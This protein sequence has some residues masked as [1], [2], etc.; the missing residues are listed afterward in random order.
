MNYTTTKKNERRLNSFFVMVILII[1]GFVLRSQDA[2]LM[3]IKSI[4]GTQA[5]VAHDFGF[6]D[7]GNIYMVGAF[8]GTMDFDPGPGTYTLNSPGTS[9]IFV[10]KMDP[11]GNFIWAK[12]MGG[13]GTFNTP[14]SMLVDSAG[15]SYIAGN[16]TGT[17]DFDP[18]VG[19]Y[20]VT[21][22]GYDIFLVKLNQNGSLVWAKT[23]GGSNSENANSL[24]FDQA[25]NIVMTGTF[26]DTVDFDPGAGVTNLTAVG[27]AD[28]FVSKLDT[29][30]NLIWAKSFG[31]PGSD[32]GISVTV[33]AA[34]NILATGGFHD[35]ADF[36]PSGATYTITSSGNDDAYVTKLNASGNFLWA[37][38]FSGTADYGK[39]NAIVTDAAGNVYTA[40]L[41][42]GVVDFDPGSGTY[43]LATSSSADPDSYVAKLDAG[44][45]LVWAKKLGASAGAEYAYAID[46]DQSGNVY[47]TGFSN[48]TADFD[49]GP[50]VYNLEPHI[51]V[52]KLSNAGNFVWARSFEGPG[53]DEGASIYV[54]DN[55]NIY[56]AGY[57]YNTV[58]FDPRA[59]VYNV[60]SNGI[61]DAFLL[62]LCQMADPVVTAN[63]PTSFCM[64][65]SV[66][67]MS[68]AFPSY[69]WS[70]GVT[71]QTT[72]IYASGN[73]SIA[74][75]NT[76]G[77]TAISPA[78]TVSVNTIPVMPS[79]IS[80]STVLCE[81]T[82]ATYS[83]P[84][85]SNATSYNWMLPS[86]WPGTSSTNTI[87]TMAMASGGTLMVS[88]TNTCGTSPTQTI[89]VTGNAL[90]SVVYNESTSMVCVTV[91]SMT[92]GNASPSGGTYSGTAVSGNT[93]NP[94]TA[95]S[96]TFAIVYTY[97][98][99][100]TCTNSDT[101]SIVVDLCTGM[102]SMLNSNAVKIYP[103]PSSGYISISGTGKADCSIENELGQTIRHFKLDNSN[104]YS[105]SMEDLNSGIY[106]IRITDQ[107]QTIMQKIVVKK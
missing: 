75:T 51:F 21:A 62:K 74:V 39:G 85:I 19:T 15:N 32:V 105:V 102:A 76:M 24:S 31:G 98:D 101:S 27:S 90:P 60:T 63:G 94:N 10:T 46:I 44:G 35:T 47:T 79:A 100:N 89:M 78:V 104:N 8:S 3:W 67:L 84:V 80:G 96:G 58:D 7:Q 88:A 6:D 107:R 16:Y 45:N 70:N 48:A 66:V 49:P 97:T 95:G 37:V 86:G 93:F 77:C 36:D 33:D 65:D 81:G 29:A 92:L 43:T 26:Y 61:A 68:T 34:G 69:A 17:T 83:V 5:D 106:F 30:A 50:A 9:G 13:L 41:L 2:N 14:W 87:S 73:Y 57:Y 25:G 99:A 22:N 28:A 52:S 20:S 59:A 91:T 56:V 72:A 53:L 103:N 71:T 40:G 23:F 12:Y 55:E 82:A 54:D 38:S 42:K 1:N 4:G 18:G 11:A 64:G